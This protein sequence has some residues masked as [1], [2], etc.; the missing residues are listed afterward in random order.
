MPEGKDSQDVVIIG[1]C[2]GDGSHGA[3]RFRDGKPLDRGS[4]RRMEHGKPIMG[5]PVVLHPRAEGPGYNVE[6]LIEEPSEPVESERPAMVNSRTYRD[7]WDEIFDRK[8]LFG[9]E[10]RPGSA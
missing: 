10:V 1:P 2:N 6:Y 5:K 9:S 3:I 4:I 8:G 7:N